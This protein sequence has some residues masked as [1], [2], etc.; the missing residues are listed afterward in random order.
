MSSFLQLDAKRSSIICLLSFAGLCSSSLA[1]DGHQPAQS[2][3]GNQGYELVWADEFDGSSVDLNNWEFQIGDGCAIGLCG[4]GNNELEWYRAENARVED[5]YLIITAKREVFQGRQYTSVRLRTLRK[6]D[7]TYGRFEM[8][9]KLPTGQ[10]LWPAFWMLPTDSV[11]GGWAASGEIDIMELVGREPNRVYGTLHYGAAWPNNVSSGTSYALREGTF[12]D[13]FHVFALEWERGEIRWY[14]DNVHYQ[15]QTSWR[16]A[17]HPFPAPFDQRFH[18]LLN[19]AVGGNWPGPPNQTT[20]FPQ[21]MV[22]DYVRVYQ[23]T[24][25]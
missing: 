16:T 6:G 18:I 23:K 17:G 1:L 22:V 24:R 8:R 13:D 9:A 15:T 2:G 7:W 19:V 20:V 11:Y 4:W 25:Q 21:T 14:V 5:G 12:A 10:G 3:D